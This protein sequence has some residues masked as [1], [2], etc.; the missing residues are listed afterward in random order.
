[1]HTSSAA[2]SHS[3]SAW[4]RRRCRCCE[5][6]GGAAVVVLWCCGVG[7]VRAGAGCAQRTCSLRV[8]GRAAVRSCSALRTAVWEAS[9][10]TSCKL[11]EL[12]EA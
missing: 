10:H 5:R 8:P 3:Q 11:H 4:A 7:L 2:K 9:S 1:L 6:Q 12:A